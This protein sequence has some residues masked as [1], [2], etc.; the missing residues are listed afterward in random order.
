MKDLFA[1]VF[2]EASICDPKGFVV[3]GWMMLGP[4]IGQILCSRSPVKTILVLCFAA[5]QPMESHVHG[6]ECLGHNFVDEECVG[7]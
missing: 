1:V 7:S 3:A 5:M 2:E 6:L 4:V